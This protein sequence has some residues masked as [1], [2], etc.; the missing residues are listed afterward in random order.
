MQA[1]RRGFSAGLVAALGLT[2]CGGGGGGVT[3]APAEAQF[4]AVPNPAFD[5]WVASFRPRAV[6]AGLPEAMWAICP[7]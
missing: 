5:A 6:A 4:P 7:A 2:A 1:T 3:R